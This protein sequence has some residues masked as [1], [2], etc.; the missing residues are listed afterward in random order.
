V[1]ASTSM[2][3]DPLAGSCRTATADT[4]RAIR[5]GA[6]GDVARAAVVSLPVVI[7]AARQRGLGASPWA[8][9]TEAMQIRA[10]AALYGPVA[11]PAG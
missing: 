10:G 3:P 1:S 8:S 2:A 9:L 7:G 4:S 6:Q 5:I 11:D